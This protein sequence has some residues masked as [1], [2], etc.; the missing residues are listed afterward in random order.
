[1]AYTSLSSLLA[2]SVVSD[3]KVGGSV[4]FDIGDFL[5]T[6][7]LCGAISRVND[8]R[9]CASIINITHVM[10]GVLNVSRLLLATFSTLFSGPRRARSFP[11]FEYRPLLFLLNIITTGWSVSQPQSAL[12]H[13]LCIQTLWKARYA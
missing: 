10:D 6:T 1:M 4:W 3:V 8:T 2:T 12:R 11:S 9:C 5:S 7:P 13:D